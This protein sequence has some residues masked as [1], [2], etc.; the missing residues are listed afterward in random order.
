VLLSD[1]DLTPNGGPTTASR[2]TYV[3]GNAA[4]RAAI[5]MREVMAQVASEHL[6]AAPDTLKFRNGRIEYDGKS[7]SFA[8]VVEWMEAEGR[9][10]KL[11]YEYTAPETK[12]LGQ[13]G[14]M[15][16]AFSYATHAA[17][18]EVDTD[19]GQVK[20]LKVV[21][22]H[23]IGRAINPLALEGQIDG[24]IVM[25]IGNA[26]TEEFPHDNGVPWAQWLA[27][28]KMPSI[29]HTPEIKSFIVEHEIS[30]GPFGAK[31]VGEISSIPIT[32][33]ITNAIYNAVGVRVRRLPVDQDSLLRAMKSGAKSVD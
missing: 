6:D 24:G 14:D 15:H 20:V 31:G 13:G 33:A 18:V 28:Y 17:L 10:T 12:P 11:V 32:P 7:A 26:L 4:R 2:Q 25:G 22:A 29:K 1:T 3:S 23:D 5:Q 19:T 8:E 9:A 27:R 30:T 21:A 16:V